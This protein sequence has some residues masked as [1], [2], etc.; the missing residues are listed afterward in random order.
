MVL[1]VARYLAYDDDR[2]W[3]LVRH[4][5]LSDEVAHHPATTVFLCRSNP[6]TGETS[7]TY[8]ANTFFIVLH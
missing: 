5:S 1:P 6:A 3:L 8:S 2:F 4:T 7:P